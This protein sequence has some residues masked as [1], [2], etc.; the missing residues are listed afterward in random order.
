MEKYNNRFLFMELMVGSMWLKHVRLLIPLCACEDII[1]HTKT[2]TTI[3]TLLHKSS[4]SASISQYYIYDW[5]VQWKSNET[6][7]S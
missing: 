4:Q 2:H 7:K 1:N 5:K 3:Q 6:M